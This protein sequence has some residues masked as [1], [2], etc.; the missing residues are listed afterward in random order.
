MTRV[1]IC[2]AAGRMGRELLSEFLNDAAVHVVGAVEH[3]GSKFLGQDAGLLIGSESAGVDVSSDLAAII[4]DADTIVDFTNPKTSCENLKNAA[5]AG[6]SAVIGTTGFSN[7]EINDIC[8]HAK[9]IP[10]VLSPNMSQGVNVLFHL[11][12]QAA[13]LLGEQFDAEIFEVHH[14]LK[15]DAPSGTALQFGRVI[16]EAREKTLEEI[17]VYGREGMIGERKKGELGILALRISDVVGEHTIVFG[18]PGERVELTHKASSRKTFANGAL[19]AVKFLQ[20]KKSGLFTM[21]DVLGLT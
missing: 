4:G 3:P 21:R 19:R 16:A 5:A 9:A 6:K 18:G 10:V 8:T 20:G 1:I 12:K 17:A 11:V 14:N 2:G 7:E 15:K 13:R